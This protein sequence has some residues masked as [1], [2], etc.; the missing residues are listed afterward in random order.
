MSDPITDEF[1]H[2]SGAIGRLRV[3]V[4]V[5]FV[6]MEG[7]LYF[8]RRIYHLLIHSESSKVGLFEVYYKIE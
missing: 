2:S 5:E 3:Q 1:Q 6:E 8:I 7:G 4:S